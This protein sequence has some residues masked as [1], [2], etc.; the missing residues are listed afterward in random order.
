MSN[1]TYPIFPNKHGNTRS[2]EIEVKCGEFAMVEGYCL[3]EGLCVKF[4]KVDADP[5]RCE[6]NEKPFCIDGKQVGLG[7]SCT[8]ALLTMPGTYVGYLC[9]K[10][11]ILDDDFQIRVEHVPC[12]DNLAVTFQGVALG[13]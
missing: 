3:P 2:C 9:L 1:R 7:G 10:E 4:N 6:H 8:T 5:C 11:E 13:A 12:L